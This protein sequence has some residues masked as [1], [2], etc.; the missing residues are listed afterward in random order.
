VY[1]RMVPPLSE[2]ERPCTACSRRSVRR[3]TGR[4][5]KNRQLSFV[6]NRSR[7]C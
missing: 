1:R 4:A 5:S 7:D 6:R 2:E 3:R